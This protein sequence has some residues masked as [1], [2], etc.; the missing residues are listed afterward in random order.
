MSNVLKGTITNPEKIYGKSAYE[1]AVMHGFDGTEEEWLESLKSKSTDEAIAAAE[2]AEAAVESA[3]QIVEEVGATAQGNI[4]KAEAEALGGIVAAKATM[5]SEIEIAAEIV[6]EAGYSETAVMSQKAVTNEMAPLFESVGLT[7]T[8]TQGSAEAKAPAYENIT[9]ATGISLIKGRKYVFNAAIDT[10][11]TDFA[12]YVRLLKE[13]GTTYQNITINHSTYT[14]AGGVTFTADD[15][16]AN[17]TVILKASVTSGLSATA[18]IDIIGDNAL[19]KMQSYFY[20]KTLQELFSKSVVFGGSNGSVGSVPSFYYG[21]TNRALLETTKFLNNVTVTPKSGW[22]MAIMFLDD[23]QKCERDTGWITE[24]T[25]ISAN[26][27]ICMQFRKAD[28]SDLTQEEIE[29]AIIIKNTPNA[30]NTNDVISS[31]TVEQGRVD[32]TSYTFVRIPRTSNGGK[33][34]RP[35]LALTSVDGSL[36][37]TKRSALNFA[38]DNDNTG[39]IVNGGLFNVA[40]MIPIGQTIIDGEV[41]ISTPQSTDDNNEHRTETECYPLCFDANGNLSAPYRNRNTITTETMIADG[42][43]NSLCGWVVLVDNYAV[44]TEEIATEIVHADRYVHNCIGQYQNGDY[45]VLACDYHGYQNG[46]ENELG[47]TYTQLAQILVD[48]GVKF[49]YAID[50]GGSA[51]LV[52]GKRQL[53]AIFEGTAGRA[54]PLVICFAAE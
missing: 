31:I 3:A 53:N 10:E 12:A 26:K 2:R 24:K 54:V 21:V 37:G 52:L 8:I 11:H 35:K 7:H 40:E 50:G 45:C 6:Q 9:L 51:E 19:L 32:G 49:A 22:T 44:C 5:L 17:M 29:T 36:R 20:D 34:I 46:I 28:N 14:H 43:V 27:Y 47:L 15:D 23:E 38:R 18:S 33:A 42:V 1:I 4:E 30:V 16:Y 41:I 39:F 48:K 25:E 13:E